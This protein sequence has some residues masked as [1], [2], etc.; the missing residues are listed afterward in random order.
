MTTRN[1]DTERI[2]CCMM[3]S[4]WASFGLGSVGFDDTPEAYT[5]GRLSADFVLDDSVADKKN[6]KHF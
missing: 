3:R 1:A 5:A 2:I 6:R 4:R